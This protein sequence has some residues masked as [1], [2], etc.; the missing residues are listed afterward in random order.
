METIKKARFETRL[1]QEQKEYFERA[2]HIAGF[3]TLSEFMLNSA[4]ELAKNIFEEHN[5]ILASKR[6]QEIFFDALINPPK[7]N[8]A[9]KKAASQYQAFINS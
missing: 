3:A 6:D 4:N 9:L 2:A 1:S 8:A 7:P 5:K